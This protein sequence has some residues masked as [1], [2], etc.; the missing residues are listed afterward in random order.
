MSSHPIPLTPH[1]EGW[2][3]AGLPSEDDAPG[4]ASDFQCLERRVELLEQQQSL[5]LEKVEAEKQVQLKG[6]VLAKFG[7]QLGVGGVSTV[8][9][10]LIGVASVYAQSAW[11]R[12]WLGRRQ[13]R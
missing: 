3:R 12:W 1:Y 7:I 4:G 9:T 13:L 2:H 11:F 6:G 5:F 10:G 8:R